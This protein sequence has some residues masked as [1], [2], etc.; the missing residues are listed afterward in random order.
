MLTWDFLKKY[1]HEQ[2]LSR[3][4]EIEEK[5]IAHVRSLN[6][7]VHEYI[8]HNIIKSNK[9]IIVDN[10]FPYDLEENLEH[11]LLW[12]NPDTVLEEV[13]VNKIICSVFDENIYFRNIHKNQSVKG[14]VHYHIFVMKNLK[15]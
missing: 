2:K 13:E 15:I 4:H 10:T 14:I 5:Y 1:N 12:I 6:G 7:K 9:Y 3:K 11:K 8:M